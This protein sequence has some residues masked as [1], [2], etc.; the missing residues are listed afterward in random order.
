[1]EVPDQK[2]NAFF[3]CIK[4][5]VAGVI[6]SRTPYRRDIIEAMLEESSNIELIIRS[7]D[8]S[9]AI[10]K[11]PKEVLVL[12]KEFTSQLSPIASNRVKDNV[13]EIRKAF[14]ANGLNHPT[15]HKQL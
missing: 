12:Y 2:E 9:I 7:L 6:S 10:G 15:N 4:R 11:N 3:K 13:D 8:V 14:I 1:M 5:D